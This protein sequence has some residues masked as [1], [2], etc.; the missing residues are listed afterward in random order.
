MAEHAVFRNRRGVVRGCR[1]K[2]AA[3]QELQRGLNG[4]LRQTR[5]IRQRAQ[6]RLNRFPSLTSSEA[7]KIKVN[8]IRR[9]LAIVADDVA[10]EDIKHVIIHWDGSA[11]S[12]HD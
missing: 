6:A 2:L 4:A 7:V 12:R 3:T 11:K 1:D 8:E 9:R 5:L 10:H